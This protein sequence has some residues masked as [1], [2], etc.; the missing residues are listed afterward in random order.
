MLSVDQTPR[1]HWPLSRIVKYTQAKVVSV[2]VN[3]PNSELIRLSG[4]LIY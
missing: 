3:T 4:Q 2:K 1:S